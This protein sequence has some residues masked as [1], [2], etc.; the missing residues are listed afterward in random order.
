MVFWTCAIA[1]AIAPAASLVV[2]AAL[3]FLA[4]R[5]IMPGKLRKLGGRNGESCRNALAY[6]SNAW[7]THR[8]EC[9]TYRKKR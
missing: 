9:P 4:A 6:R 5:E 2:L 1:F 8:A 7:A 3:T